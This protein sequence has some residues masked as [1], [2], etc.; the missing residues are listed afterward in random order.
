MGVGLIHMN[1]RMYDAKLGRFISPDNF[2][3]EPFNTQ[4]F[5]RF[6]Y[7]FNNPLKYVDPSGEFFW[8]AVIIGAVLGGTTAVINGGDF[9][10][11]LLGMLIGGVAAGVGAGV[12]NLA[13]GGAFFGAKAVSVVGFWAG[14]KVG[15]LAG[16]AGGFTGSAL[17]TWA[18]GGSFIDGIVNGFR[19]GVQGAL[20][21]AAVGGI[22]GGIKAVKEGRRFFDGAKVEDLTMVDQG[23]PFV[24]QNDKAQCV[25]ACGE[26]ATNGNVSQDQIR[27]ALA[28]N[29]DPSNIGLFDG[30]MVKEISKLDGG[31]AKYART[32]LNKY[33]VVDRLKKGHQ[34]FANL[35]GAESNHM[36]L[37]NKVVK[38]TITKLSG[39]IKTKFLYYA[40]DPLKGQYTSLSKSFLNNGTNFW[41]RIK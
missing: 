12:A 30:D 8:I 22:T 14:A 1:G 40:M 15:A 28:K 34:I 26:S 13:A 25:A 33:L 41:F 29:S 6:G 35:K 4:S 24:M 18:N 7:G 9:G 3:Q 17:N 16:F 32:K 36:V 23:N 37:L 11:I 21:G 20:V 2:V 39:V 10:D 38:R 31:V 5:N 27:D 19:A